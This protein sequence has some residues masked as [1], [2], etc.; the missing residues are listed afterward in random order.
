MDDREDD[1]TKQIMDLMLSLPPIRRPDVWAA[2]TYNNTFCV[3]CGLGDVK[4]PNPN[5]QC[6]NDE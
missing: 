1:V 2:V 4:N 6:T 3:F 5:C